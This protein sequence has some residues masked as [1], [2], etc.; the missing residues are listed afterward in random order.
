LQ[1]KAL[2][3]K[4]QKTAGLCFFLK[5]KYFDIIGRREFAAKQKTSHVNDPPCTLKHLGLSVQSP[6][7]QSPVSDINPPPTR[8]DRQ[9]HGSPE[10]TG[11]Q[12]A[13]ASQTALELA[14]LTEQL[15][16]F[17]TNLGPE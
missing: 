17:R 4:N 8:G 6:E 11:S 14:R 13:C 10:G 2:A 16:V 9:E 7:L 5:I 12:A 3:N 1:F 15:K